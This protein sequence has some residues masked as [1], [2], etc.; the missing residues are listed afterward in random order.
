METNLEIRN[1]FRYQKL[2]WRLKINFEVKD[3]FVNQR[4]IL[5]K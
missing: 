5:L 3:Q 2:I 1:L 4:L